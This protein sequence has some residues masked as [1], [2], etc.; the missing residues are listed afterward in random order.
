M[1]EFERKATFGF[2]SGVDGG[3]EDQAYQLFQQHSWHLEDL[4][5]LQIQEAQPP[6]THPAKYKQLLMI[7]MKRRKKRRE[8]NM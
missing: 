8:M 7:K 1:S 2:T 4:A 6:A 5:C 3:S